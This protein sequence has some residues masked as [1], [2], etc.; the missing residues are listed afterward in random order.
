MKQF[1]VCQIDFHSGFWDGPNGFI[2]KGNTL[3][4]RKQ[5]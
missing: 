4:L 5:W 2:D 1:S 3:V